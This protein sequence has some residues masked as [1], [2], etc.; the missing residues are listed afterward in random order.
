MPC[1]RRDA[2]TQGLRK[3][4]PLAVALLPGAALSKPGDERM[5]PEL[6]HVVEAPAIE[7][8]CRRRNA[9]VATARHLNEHSLHQGQPLDRDRVRAVHHALHQDGTEGEG[10]GRREREHR[11]FGTETVLPHEAQKPIV[12][13]QYQWRYGHPGEESYPVRM[14]EQFAAHVP[15]DIFDLPLPSGSVLGR[16]EP[17]K[18]TLECK[19]EQFALCLEVRVERHRRDA[20]FV[21]ERSDGQPRQTCLVDGCEGG[22]EDGV[23]VEAGRASKHAMPGLREVDH[24]MMVRPCTSNATNPE[25]MTDEGAH[26]SQ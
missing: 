6:E 8:R 2:C 12:N 4:T 26:S 11:R 24:R 3:A 5:Q 18:E 19:I 10:H 1:A 7:L 22:V 21:C 20:Q 13:V 25:A 14:L 17:L 15:A 9:R 16:N 23:P